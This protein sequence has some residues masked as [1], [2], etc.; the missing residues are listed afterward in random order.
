MADR[1]MPAPRPIGSPT[2]NQPIVGAA[3]PPVIAPGH[4]FGTVTDKI[5]SIVLTRKTPIGWYVGFGIALL[6]HRPAAR[7]AHLPGDQGHR[8]L[9]QQ[10][11]G[12]LGVRHHQLR[13]VDRHRPRRHAD[14]GDSAAAEADVAD[15]DQPLRRGDDAVRRRRARASSRCSTPAARGSPTGCSRTRTR[16]ASGRSSAARSSGTCSRSRPT[17]PCRCCSGSSA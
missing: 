4:T 6:L 5:S 9:G 1:H 10:H 12:R 7:L 8:H 17:R 13:L 11:P 14:L 2:P 3:R 16:W 15:L